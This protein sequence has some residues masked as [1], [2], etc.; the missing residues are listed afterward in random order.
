MRSM[1]PAQSSVAP[2]SP[3][4]ASATARTRR[5]SSASKAPT[6]SASRSNCPRIRSP[7]RIN[8]TS[9]LRTFADSQYEEAGAEIEEDLSECSVILAV[10]EVPI[11][12]VQLLN[13]APP[14]EAG[15]G[16]DRRG[17]GAASPPNDRVTTDDENN[18]QP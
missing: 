2:A 16:N 10:K 3:P 14:L 8:T 12:L 4:K 5:W 9:S 7:Q 18:Q 17:T 11:D 6:A 1:V 15:F 13:E